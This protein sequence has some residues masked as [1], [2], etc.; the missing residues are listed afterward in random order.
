PV[1]QARQWIVAGQ[2]AKTA[3][4]RGELREHL[5]VAALERLHLIGEALG[6]RTS[7]PRPATSGPSSA[8]NRYVAGT[9]RSRPRCVS[10]SENASVAS[11]SSPMACANRSRDGSSS[12]LANSIPGSIR[13]TAVRNPA[14]DNTTLCSESST[15]SRS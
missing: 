9:S 2:L 12:E 15:T 7:R 4:H 10:S 13:A 11:R 1:E 14:L 3:R 6:D 8:K 5:G